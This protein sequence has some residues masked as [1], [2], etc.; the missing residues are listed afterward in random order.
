MEE[1]IIERDIVRPAPNNNGARGVVLGI[2]IAVWVILLIIYFYRQG[3]GNLK[4]ESDRSIITPI[5]DS[6]DNT[7][8]PIYD[9]TEP[10]LDSRNNTT[11]PIDGSV[12]SDATVTL[13]ND[14]AQ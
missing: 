13:T 9:N 6:I 8:T 3:F 14:S 4:T 2:I 11:A 7:S 5:I 12:S 10:V 1:R